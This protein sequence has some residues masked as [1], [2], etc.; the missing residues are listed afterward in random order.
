MHLP[1][2]SFSNRVS[3]LITSNFRLFRLLGRLQLQLPGP[4]HGFQLL[5]LRLILLPQG[6]ILRMQ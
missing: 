2:V 6:N 3:A 4:L 5:A 1:N